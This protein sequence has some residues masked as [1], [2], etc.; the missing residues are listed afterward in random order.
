MRCNKCA[1]FGHD[2]SVSVPRAQTQSHPAFKHRKNHKSSTNW[3][4]APNVGLSKAPIKPPVPC[5]PKDQLDG[6]WT[7]VEGKHKRKGKAHGAL[8]DAQFNVN[9]FS[10]LPLDTDGDVLN[11]ALEVVTTLPSLMELCSNPS[12]SHHFPSLLNNECEEPCQSPEQEAAA[13]SEDGMDLGP[14]H[15]TSAP[16]SPI[17][18]RQRKR[19]AKMKFSGSRP[20]GRHST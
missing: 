13:V 10:L 15:R 20:K 19:E 14:V 18:S 4:V 6:N 16:V 9:T 1:T 5:D 2:C 17:S 12:T 7:L 11:P 3:V 8:E